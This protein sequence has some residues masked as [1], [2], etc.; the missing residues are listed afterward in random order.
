MLRNWM[1]KYG[2]CGVVVITS[3]SHAEGREF[4]P[5]QNL[6]IFSSAAIQKGI[7]QSFIFHQVIRYCSSSSL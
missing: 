5:R 1:Y 6:I 4:E 2:F 3:A 7:I